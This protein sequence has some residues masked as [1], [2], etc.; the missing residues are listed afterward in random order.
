M[1]FNPSPRTNPNPNPITNLVSLL[2]QFPLMNKEVQT[3]LFLVSLVL[4]RETI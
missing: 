2:V 1:I 3:F 4:L